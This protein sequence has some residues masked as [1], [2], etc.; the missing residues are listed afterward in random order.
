MT[1]KIF[2]AVASAVVQTDD[3]P[4]TLQGGVT[5]VREG[6]ALLE[7]RS[8]LFRELDIHYEV[9]DARKAPQDDPK[10]QPVKSEAKAEAK[11]EDAEAKTEPVKAAAPS[12]A[13]RRGP[14]KTGA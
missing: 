14:R 4:V 12:P 10:P 9:E 13:H 1:G 3:G 6:H 5:R 2:I 11:A 8:E 7:G